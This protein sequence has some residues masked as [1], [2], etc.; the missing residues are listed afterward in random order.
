LIEQEDFL[1]AW[2]N[3]TLENQAI[4]SMGET[5]VNKK[6]TSETWEFRL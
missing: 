5:N 4:S 2:L 3:S 6:V 1:E